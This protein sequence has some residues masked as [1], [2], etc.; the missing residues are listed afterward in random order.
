M[1]SAAEI[2][3]W[4]IDHL[5]D[6]L[7]INSD[8]IDPNRGLDGSLDSTMGL[9]MVGVLQDYLGFKLPQN[10]AYQYP[11]I[12]AAAQALADL[13]AESSKGA[14]RGARPPPARAAATDH[15]P[16]DAHSSRPGGRRLAP[17]GGR[18]RHARGRRGPRRAF[19]A[20]PAVTLRASAL[21]G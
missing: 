19:R 10:I 16:E 20:R 17:R 13:S 18:G 5:A 14:G 4:M 1:K 8:S 6:N 11:T 9:A 3:D 7:H 21:P 12:N 15:A 2:R